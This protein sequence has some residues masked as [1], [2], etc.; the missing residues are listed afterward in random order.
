MTVLRQDE[1]VGPRADAHAQQVAGVEAQAPAQVGVRDELAALPV[2]PAREGRGR[3]VAG[4]G[5]AEA[6]LGARAIMRSSMS[7]P[8]TSTQAVGTASAATAASV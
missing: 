7:V 1:V 5:D 8:R 4:V 2:E 6:P 3:D